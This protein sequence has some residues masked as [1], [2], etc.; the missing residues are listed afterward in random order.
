MAV[1]SLF[2]LLLDPAR[3]EDVGGNYY[4]AMALDFMHYYDIDP[5]LIVIA[6]PPE[7]SLPSGD[8]TNLQGRHDI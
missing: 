2:V 6:F 1:G 7:T 4:L 8:L 5:F 3:G